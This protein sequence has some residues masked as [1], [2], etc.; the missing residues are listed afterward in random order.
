MRR[1]GGLVRYSRRFRYSGRRYSRR[2]QYVQAI[3]NRK[4]NLELFSFAGHPVVLPILGWATAPRMP[5]MHPDTIS[6]L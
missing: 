4:D 3:K 6:S 1:Q 2:Y 5:G